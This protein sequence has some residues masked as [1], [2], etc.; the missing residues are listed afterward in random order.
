VVRIGFLGALLLFLVLWF[1]RDVIAL[2]SARDLL[3]LAGLALGAGAVLAAILTSTVV[4]PSMAARTSDTVEA[5]RAVAQGDLTREPSEVEGDGETARVAAAVR[6]A[7]Q[8]LRGSIGEAR[9]AAG[10]VALRAQDL[11]MQSTAAMSVAQR[12]HEA[13]SGV[14]RRGATLVELARGAQAELGRVAEGA[15]RVVEE[16]RLQRSREARV[17]ALSRESLANLRTGTD[18]L[19]TLAADVGGSAEEL[20]ALAGASEEIRS[21]VTLV[22]KMARQSKLLALN[23]AMEA[24]RAGE[25]GSGFAVVASEVRRLA[26]SS[27]EAADRTDQLVTDVLE[28]LERVRVAGMRGVEVVRAAQH[29]ASLGL[30]TLE[31]LDREASRALAGAEVD[32]VATVTAASEAVVLRLDQLSREAEALSE[33]LREA[34]TTTVG[35]QSRLQELTAAANAL[36]RATARVTATLNALRTERAAPAVADA[37]AGDEPSAGDLAVQ[38]GV[39]G[40]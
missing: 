5:L 30:A 34:A 2:A 23:A 19:A 4:L 39:S 25:Q 10:D 28:R 26:R 16:A 6:S 18:A 9:G 37:P 36:T 11:A 32:E 1:Q 15:A 7:V 12:A 27:S 29:G 22:R 20:R 14:A 3:I 17:Q 40:I 31:T 8:A 35:Q 33:A 38:G 21:F 13:S 24:A